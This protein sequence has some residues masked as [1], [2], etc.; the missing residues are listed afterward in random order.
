MSRS[1][2][3]S[4]ASSCSAWGSPRRRA[5]DHD[6]VDRGSSRTAAARA[7]GRRPGD[8]ADTNLAQLHHRRGRTLPGAATRARTLYRHTQDRR[9]P[10]GRVRQRD[11]H[12]RRHRRR[13]RDMQVSNVAGASRRRR[14]RRRADPL[15]RSRHVDENTIKSID[16]GRKFEDLLTLTPGVSIVQGPDGDE[17]TPASAASSTTSTSTA[18]TTTTGSSASRRAA[19]ASR[20]TSRSKRSRN[21]R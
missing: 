2:R 12:R 5:R 7:P 1:S 9:L 14:P 11:R 10:D 21:S 20:S 13:Q 8:N 15:E 4:W 17:S 3:P 19:S 6:V 16:L 18:A